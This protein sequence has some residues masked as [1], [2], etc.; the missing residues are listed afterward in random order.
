MVRNAPAGSEH[1]ATF[2][3]MAPESAVPIANHFIGKM[4][5]LEVT[6]VQKDVLCRLRVFLNQPHVL[7]FI[8]AEF[9]AY[10]FHDHCESY[11]QAP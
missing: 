4:V 7:P 1:R 10:L 8:C 5:A 11:M 6:V 3:R 2:A 9:G